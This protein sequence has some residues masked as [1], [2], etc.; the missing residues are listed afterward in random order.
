MGNDGHLLQFGGA[1]GQGF[2]PHEV[3]GGEVD[4]D[5]HWGIHSLVKGNHCG[6]YKKK[7]EEN[8]RQE[9]GGRRQGRLGVRQERRVKGG[10]AN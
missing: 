4:G 5:E 1:G 3:H 10:G 2:P 8:K 7:A 6:H 9:A